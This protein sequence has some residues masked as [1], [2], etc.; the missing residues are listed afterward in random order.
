M[1][2]NYSYYYNYVVDFDSRPTILYIFSKIKSKPAVIDG[3][4]GN[5]GHLSTLVLHTTHSYGL[6]LP[7]HSARAITWI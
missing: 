1:L 5:Q 7:I 3:Y 6:K 2:K 4:Y